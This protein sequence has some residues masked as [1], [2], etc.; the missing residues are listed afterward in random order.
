MVDN[1]L[2]L[3][4]T[5]YSRILNRI[6]WLLHI[7]NSLA[8]YESWIVH[9]SVLGDNREMFTF[10]FPLLA[11]LANELGARVLWSAILV[12]WSNLLLKW[13]MKGDRPYW[14]IGQTMLYNDET[15]PRLKQFTNTCEAGPGTPSGHIMMNVAVFYVIVRGLAELTWKSGKFNLC[16]KVL[17]NTLLYIVYILWIAGVFVSRLY[18]QAHF[19][20]QCVLGCVIGLLI[21]Q[22]CH[23][24]KFLL[25]LN[26]VGAISIGCFV[27]MSAIGLY[28]FLLSNGMDP[29][30]TI[31]L[32]LQY[33][34]HSEYVKIDTQPFYLVMRMTGAAL[35]LGLGIASEQREYVLKNKPTFLRSLLTIKGG[36]FI[37]K[38]ATII[39]ANI[40]KDDYMLYMTLSLGLN[41]VLP[42]I[43]ISLFPHF[44]LSFA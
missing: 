7:E 41:T 33:C 8:P 11:G 30:W 31:P 32:A 35:G 13:C 14:W 5:S 12:E 6:F 40:P 16:Q 36:V 22:F 39:Q 1:T 19:I 24:S 4:N 44:L 43:V 17:V 20:H 29:L 37:G 34:S 9:I 10:F 38:I 27:V 3:Y 21:G 42:L 25:M 23:K 15:R 18:I 28:L 2:P 26:K